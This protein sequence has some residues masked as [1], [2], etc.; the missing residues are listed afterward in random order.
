MVL[1]HQCKASAVE[2]F[3]LSGSKRVHPVWL[4]C[5]DADLVANSEYIY[6]KA[7]LEC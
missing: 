2:L 3:L 4:F 7:R 6:R 5:R 1:G